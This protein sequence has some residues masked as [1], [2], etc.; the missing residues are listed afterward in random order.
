MGA[1]LAHRS[2]ATVA[3]ATPSVVLLEG[4]DRTTAASAVTSSN[5][6]RV[7]FSGHLY[8]VEE[9][10]SL[11][12]SRTTVDGNQP[13]ALIA[14]L[15]RDHGTAF[16]PRLDGSF[17]FAVYDETADELL[18]VN[19]RFSSRP[20]YWAEL[21]GGGIAFGTRIHTVLQ[22]P[23]ISRE[24]D[25][26]A[27]CELIHY[28]RVL[29][30]RTLNEATSMMR[31]GTALRVSRGQIDETRWFA[32]EYRPEERSEDEWA[33]E[34][35]D[36]FRESVAK[37]V[38]DAR[39]IGLLL[40]GGLDSRMIVA[41][42][43]RPI[44]CF[45]FNDTKNQE[46]EKAAEIAALRSYPVTYLQRDPDHYASI[47][48]DAVDIGDSLYAFVHGHPIGLI[49]TDTVD[50]MLHGHAPE[51]YFRGPNLPRQRQEIFGKHVRT[52]VTPL[53]REDVANQMMRRLAYS[54]FQKRPGR[55]F[56]TEIAKDLD[57]RMLASAEEL[58]RDAQK[59]SD[60]PYDWFIWPDTFFQCRYPSFLF[61]LA[62]RAYAPERSAVFHNPVLDL[63]QRM[64]VSMRSS[65]RI[66]L[67]AL[68]RIGPDIAA[69]SDA[70][71]GYS[72]FA[73]WRRVFVGNAVRKAK[74]VA[75]RKPQ[76]V[77]APG[78]T[79]LSWPNFRELI[80]HNSALRDLIEDVIHDPEALDP[81]IFDLEQIDAAFNEHLNGVA[82]HD[83]SLF[84]LTTF[85]EWHRRYGPPGRALA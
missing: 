52:V 1:T 30:T 11:V 40:S 69:V 27:V 71:T 77:R 75:S 4:R 46:Y 76:P 18:V 8:N 31:P 64:P 51:L 35:S 12:T 42:T 80:I 34:L 83:L 62:I 13:G 73:S 19:D 57:E 20:V 84:L 65:S 14:A 24:V 53:A 10:R 26:T 81:G 32:M 78:H 36:T 61:E 48:S 67:R 72:P 21:R 38:K 2:G 9:M 55:F 43:P 45:H 49:P 41:A 63:H 60:D 17:A 50:V 56:V 15:Y 68:R 37:T 44:E 5:G 23:G 79:A 28:Q 25:R 33:E 54:Q 3:W 66:W 6:I 47:F 82:N 74:R 29:S 22:V 70:N 39:R 58:V 85:G 7:V 16:I 59:S